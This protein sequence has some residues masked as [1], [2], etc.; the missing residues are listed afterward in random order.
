M[1]KRP[2]NRM[3]PIIDEAEVAIDF[4]DKFYAGTF[5]RHA[6]FEARGEN[7]GLMIKLL[8]DE[9]EKRQVE[10]HLHHHL[11]A[12]ILEEWAD[13]LADQPPMQE[14][15]RDTLKEAIQK[16]EKALG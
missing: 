15:H 2:K 16:V 10:I 7:D 6:K 8:R 12:D 4:P 11:L 5:S 1:K 9:G 3:H 13:S 14:A